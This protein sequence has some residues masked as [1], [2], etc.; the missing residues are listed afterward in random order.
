MIKLPDD[1]TKVIQKN[2]PNV[3]MIHVIIVDTLVFVQ[4]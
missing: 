2:S 1:W 3:N 4:H